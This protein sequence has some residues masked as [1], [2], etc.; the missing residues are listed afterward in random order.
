MSSKD[1]LPT[2]T[3]LLGCA[4]DITGDL[5]TAEHIRR[6]RGE[7]PAASAALALMPEILNA[8]EALYE[9]VAGDWAAGSMSAPLGERDEADL[10]ALLEKVRGIVRETEVNDGR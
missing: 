9:Y 10:A 4:P 2:V 8:L 3:E 1:D 7:R 5:T 6:V